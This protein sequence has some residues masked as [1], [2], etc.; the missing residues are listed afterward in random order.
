M[1]ELYDALIEGIDAA[2]KV[3]FLAC[4]IAQ[5]I[6]RSDGATGISPILD[7]TWR[8]LMMKAKSAGMPLRDLAACI[9]SWEYNEASLGLAAI[10][11]W[12]NSA[13]RLRECGLNISDKAFVEDRSADPF[14][15]LQREIKGKNVAVIGHF[16][17]IDQ[18][19]APV[20]NLSV[21][22][23]FNPKE[24][25]YPEQAAEYL[26][27]ESDYVFISSYAFVEKT[28]PHYL[29]ISKNA[30]VTLVGPSTTVA[31]QLFD[32]GADYL[33]GYVIKDGDL[34]QSVALGVGVN[35]HATGQK[36]NLK[37]PGL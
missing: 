11:A 26:L 27:P 23:K 37:R 18:L 31:P 30:V 24:N 20:C 21:I 6:V 36:V 15:Q 25:D 7:E 9:K 17:Y 19:F 32:F 28:L 4:G 2:A 12:Y 3:D 14:I 10:N 5:S 22:E 13:S 35:I 1:W 16:P 29:E 34:A 8:P 33:A